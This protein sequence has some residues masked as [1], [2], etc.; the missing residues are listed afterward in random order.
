MA[1]HTCVFP[2][3]YVAPM[4]KSNLFLCPGYPEYSVCE[5]GNIYRT[6]TMKMRKT[7]FKSSKRIRGKVDLWRCGRRRTFAVARVVLSAKLG[8]VLISCEEACHVDGNPKN[9]QMS[10]LRAGDHLNNII[11]D[12]EL[13]RLE[14]TEH[15]LERAISRLQVLLSTRSLSQAMS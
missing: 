2:R 5:G 9:N 3:N 7:F 4:V 11:D 14:T 1:S 8:R 10:N 6:E 12:L 13:G 15:Y